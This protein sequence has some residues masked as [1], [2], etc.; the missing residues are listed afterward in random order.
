MKMNQLQI[1][2]HPNFGSIE[3]I[4]EDGKFLF[5]ATDSAKVLKYSNPR[6]A[7][8]D[9]C[10][11][12]GVTIRSVLTEG[13]KQNKKFI[14]EGNLYRLIARSQLPEAE[15]FEQWI[16]DDLIPRIRK[17]GRYQLVS[18][19]GAS[20]IEL[21]RLQSEVKLKNAEAR[22]LN[23][24]TKRFQVVMGT[25]E[26]LPNLSPESKQSLLSYGMSIFTDQKLIEDPQI[27]TTYTAEQ[28]AEELGTSSNMIGRIANKIGIKTEQYGI[29]ILSK[30]KY[31]DK[32]VSQFVYY[33]SGK[34]AVINAYRKKAS[35]E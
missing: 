19:S 23:A 26:K 27:K 25:A 24:K 35:G 10:R 22:L 7:I 5:G 29:N 32:Q 9:H 14:T 21:K 15:V 3:I 4:E 20:D 34:Q 1:F 2:N 6:K 13:G 16:F 12:E 8:K 17:D 33:E 18:N 30:S 28:I 11:K 31:S